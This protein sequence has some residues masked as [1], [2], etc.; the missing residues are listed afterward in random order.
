V[1][2]SLTNQKSWV[3]HKVTPECMSDCPTSQTLFHSSR[4]PVQDYHKTPLDCATQTGNKHN[5][6][7]E[8]RFTV[9]QVD[10]QT[11]VGN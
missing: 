7:G 9:L 8:V 4:T 10:R 3:C 6:I 11:M 5:K 1:G 2:L